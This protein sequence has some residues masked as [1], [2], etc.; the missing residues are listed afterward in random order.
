MT[1]KSD[2][3]TDYDGT[4]SPS[5]SPSPAQEESLSAEPTYSEP[6]ERFWK[7]YPKRR[8]KINA[9][10]EWKKKNLDGQIDMILDRLQKQIVNKAELIKAGQFAAEFLDPERWIKYESWNDEL[11]IVEKKPHSAHIQEF[12]GKFGISAE[13]IMEENKK[14]AELERRKNP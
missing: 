5:P 3:M 4:P 2:I 11:E 7:A 9:G 14:R 1:D 8:K 13:E 12:Q 6:F 10:K